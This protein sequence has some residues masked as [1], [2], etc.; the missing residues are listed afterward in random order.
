MDHKLV[1]DHK[2]VHED[3]KFLG[4]E[5][6]KYLLELK[7]ISFIKRDKHLRR[8]YT[9]RS[10]YRFE[11]SILYSTLLNNHVLLM[12]NGGFI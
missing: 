9:R 7:E 1:C 2:V 11:Y 6:N 12:F 10:Y 3:V 4:N 5:C 8:T